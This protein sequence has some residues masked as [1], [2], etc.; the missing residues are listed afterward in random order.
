MLSDYNPMF[1]DKYFSTLK[2]E[3]VKD[4]NENLDDVPD[5]YLQIYKIEKV[6][7]ALF[8]NTIGLKSCPSLDVVRSVGMYFRTNIKLPFVELIYALK[9]EKE[10]SQKDCLNYLF[11][12]N[13]YLYHNKGVKN[14]S[15]FYF[16]KDI[17]ELNRNQKLTLIVMLDNS[18]LY[19]P[20]KRPEKVKS[21]V[22]L[23][24]RILDKKT[25]N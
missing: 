17:N 23:F 21:K 5:L 8:S 7:T 3:I 9:I 19:N 14:A 16:H 13:D 12:R 2:E 11:L 22:L 18:S 24:E 6:R 20:I 1:N 10:F 15:L 25:L 4:R